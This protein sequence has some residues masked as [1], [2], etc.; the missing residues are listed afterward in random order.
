[1]SK[2]KEFPDLTA[3]ALA[4]ALAGRRYPAMVRV[5]QWHERR[6]YGAFL[7]EALNQ[8]G[9]SSADRWSDGSIVGKLFAIANNLHAPPPPPP[10]RDQMEQALQNLLRYTDDPAG[11]HEGSLVAE[12]ADTIRRGIAHHCKV[13]P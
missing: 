3:Q 11:C 5:P 12:W 8:A 6:S 4:A 9:L 7:R 1:M 2:H 13:Q 10:T